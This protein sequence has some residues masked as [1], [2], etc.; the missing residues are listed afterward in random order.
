MKI[1]PDFLEIDYSLNNDAYWASHAILNN[2]F[3]VYFRYSDIA[4]LV[5]PRYLIVEQGAFDFGTTQSFI[6]KEI[7]KIRGIYNSCGMIDKFRISWFKG[8]HETAPEL[9]MPIIDEMISNL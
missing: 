1:N 5:F 7:D 2:S 6:V 8:F 4:K 3:S 9:I